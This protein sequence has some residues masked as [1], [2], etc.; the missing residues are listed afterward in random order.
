MRL[1]LLALLLLTACSDRS[2]REV[3]DTSDAP[4]GDERDRPRP[5]PWDDLDLDGERPDALF[6][7]VWHD[8]PQVELDSQRWRCR[9]S[10]TGPARHGFFDLEGRVLLQVDPPEPDWIPWRDPLTDIT[11]SMPVSAAGRDRMLVV[12]VEPASSAAPDTAGRVRHAWLADGPTEQAHHWLSWEG[13][14]AD[15]PSAPGVITLPGPGQT[16][17]LGHE[18]T[19]LRI[20]ADPVE[21]GVVWVAPVYATPTLDTPALIRLS[22]DDVS[23]AR[24]WS[25]RELL[26]LH[27]YRPDVD[28]YV[29][30]SLR[31]IH[32]QRRTRV[33]VNLIGV[34]QDAQDF[35]IGGPAIVTV[36]DPISETVVW[37]RE[38]SWGPL[39]PGAVDLIEDAAPAWLSTAYSDDSGNVVG[40]I[41]Y[42]NRVSELIIADMHP[43]GTIRCPRSVALLDA[44][45]GTA[46]MHGVP[47]DGETHGG[48]RLQVVHRGETV[49]ELDG[50][51][52][53]LG[54][55][56]VF[57]HGMVVLDGL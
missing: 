6:G 55:T 51:R 46:I 3:E 13:R 10:T 31:V 5:S 15:S 26:V 2:F 57:L 50:L 8:R 44:E 29:P 27:H 35:D 54:T 9:A 25:A 33:A 14:T 30:G 56:P 49:L 12:S 36:L 28:G 22:V 40:I 42:R 16:L 23:T 4:P 47:L 39:G 45:S 43:G 38:V 1:P 18:I 52:E 41:D 17:D 7:G 19:D 37:T 53:G 20:A 21:Q 11:A 24:T 34:Q 48:S 32:D